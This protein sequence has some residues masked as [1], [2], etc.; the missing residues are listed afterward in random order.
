MRRK[1]SVEE[2]DIEPAE[3]K[4]VSGESCSIPAS[5]TN[6]IIAIGRIDNKDFCKVNEEALAYYVSKRKLRDECQAG[7]LSGQDCRCAEY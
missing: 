2:R 4:A 3:P 6:D 7:V 1:Y 5:L